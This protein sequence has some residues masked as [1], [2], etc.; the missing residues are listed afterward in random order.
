MNIID[1][2][3]KQEQ[4]ILDYVVANGACQQIHQDFNEIS[5][6]LSNNVKSGAETRRALEIR[7]IK[8]KKMESEFESVF[9]LKGIKP[10]N[11]PAIF[12]INGEFFY[13]DVADQHMIVR[14]AQAFGCRK[15]NKAKEA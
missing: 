15:N 7:L 13:I 4:A 12:N 1:L 8:R 6:S 11:L 2:T 5:A 14:K 9:Q 3:E 10:I